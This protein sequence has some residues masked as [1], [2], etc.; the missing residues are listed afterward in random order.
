LLS[1][2]QQA[3]RLYASRAIAAK[4]D[5]YFV[6]G[7]LPTNALAVM[8]FVLLKPMRWSKEQLAGAWQ[9]FAQL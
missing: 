4:F 8:I 6:R 5:E 1:V 2:W 9:A 7:V 3:G